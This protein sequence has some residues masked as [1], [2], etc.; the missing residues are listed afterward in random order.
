MVVEWSVKTAGI[1]IKFQMSCAVLGG[2]LKTGAWCLV[3]GSWF[4]HFTF[5]PSPFTFHFPSGLGEGLVQTVGDAKLSGPVVEVG[6][7]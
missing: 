1:E 3:L 2:W 5:H 7:V 6:L 4:L